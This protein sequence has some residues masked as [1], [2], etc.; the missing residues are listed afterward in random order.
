MRR[1]ARPTGTA[2]YPGAVLHQENDPTRSPVTGLLLA[3]GGG[4]RLGGR[5]KALLPYRGA[6]LVEH[7][8]RALV[9]GGCGRVCVVLGAAAA[10]VQARAR[11]DGA[12]VVENPDW[13]AGMGGS[14]RVG[15]AAVSGERPGGVAAAESGAAL[16]VLVDQPGVSPRAVARVR[17]AYEGP[18]SLAS[19]AYGGRRGHPV[20]LGAAH[21]A[22]VAA[23]AEGD[24]G[25]RA[26]LR[27]HPPVC[28]ECGDVGDPADIDTPEDLARL[29][30]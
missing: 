3:A 8:V 18:A 7:A 11:L 15:L 9:D 2:P 29:D 17:A 21:F 1:P 14:L 28:V 10:T 12:E 6:P 4:S 27:R 23:A 5:P 13:A 26:Y 24:R 19:A 16:V 20:L 25:A 30:D 22:G